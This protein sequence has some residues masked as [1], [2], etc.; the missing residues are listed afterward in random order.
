MTFAPDVYN[1]VCALA[2]VLQGNWLYVITTTVSAIVG[3][4]TALLVYRENNAAL[5]KSVEI[6]LLNQY[7]THVCAHT[8]K[9]GWRPVKTSK[10]VWR[11][12]SSNSV[13]PVDVPHRPDREHMSPAPKYANTGRKAKSFHGPT[14]IGRLQSLQSQLSALRHTIHRKPRVTRPSRSAPTTSTRCYHRNVT[15]SEGDK[16]HKDTTEGE[17]EPS[18][19][20]RYDRTIE[21]TSE[22]LIGY[23]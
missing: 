20:T 22:I 23:V 6:D 11:S 7:D 8:P 15:Q 19:L 4:G 9:K 5:L 10:Q 21:F 17:A 14:V 3:F 18:W 2:Q 16:D 13:R 12:K 1:L